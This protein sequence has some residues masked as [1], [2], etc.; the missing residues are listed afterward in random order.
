MWGLGGLAE[1]CDEAGFQVRVLGCG[2][3]HFHLGVVDQAQ[4]QLGG[5]QAGAGGALAVSVAGQSSEVS[6][7]ERGGAVLRQD[8]FGSY[9]GV[10]V[11]EKGGPP[12]GGQVDPGAW[13]GRLA[14]MRV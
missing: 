2:A 12:R 10:R 3:A 8:R 13:G 1:T 5:E 7:R 4:C 11:S 9:L 14:Y 6:R